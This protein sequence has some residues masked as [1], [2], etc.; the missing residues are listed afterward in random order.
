MRLKKSDSKCKEQFISLSAMQIAVYKFM[1]VL[2]NQHGDD[3][4][5]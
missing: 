1:T 2:V 4:L 5:V 3:Q